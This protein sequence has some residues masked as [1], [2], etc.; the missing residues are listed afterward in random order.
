MGGKFRVENRKT[1]VRLKKENI[2]YIFSC[3]WY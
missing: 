1:N 3:E 2:Y